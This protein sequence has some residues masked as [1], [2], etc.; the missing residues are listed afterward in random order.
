M[1]DMVRLVE[2]LIPALR[3]YARALLRDPA[4]ADDLVQELG[5]EPSVGELAERLDAGLFA[6]RQV[7]GVV[8]VPDGVQVGPAERDD[9]RKGHAFRGRRSVEP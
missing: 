9:R 1:S 7:D 4:D 3:R 8:D 5:R 6:P 2:P